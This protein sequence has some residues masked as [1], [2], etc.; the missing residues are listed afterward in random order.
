LEQKQNPFRTIPTALTLSILIFLIPKSM[1]VRGRW[2]VLVL[3]LAI[4]SAIGCAGGSKSPST[5]P[6]TPSSQSYTLS[7]T[8]TAATGGSIQL[9]LHLTVQN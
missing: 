2:L 8:F 9:P 5:T 1:R 6:V 4:T 7:A 3:A